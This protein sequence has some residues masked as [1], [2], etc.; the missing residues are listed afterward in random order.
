MA[1]AVIAGGTPSAEPIPNS[2]TPTVPMV[3][4]ELPIARDTIEHSSSAVTRKK[5]G[6]M[7]SSP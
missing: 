4:R 1:P 5:R 6:E 7:I 3:D 2:A